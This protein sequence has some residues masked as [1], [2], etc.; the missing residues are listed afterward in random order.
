[1]PAIA[2]TIQSIGGPPGRGAGHLLTSVPPLR[3]SSSLARVIAT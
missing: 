3:I 1:M 2:G